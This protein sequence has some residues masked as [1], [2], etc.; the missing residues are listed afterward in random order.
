M[1]MRRVALPGI[2]RRQEKGK[3]SDLA[4][5]HGQGWFS[6]EEDPP[7][8]DIFQ[9]PFTVLRIAYFRLLHDEPDGHFKVNARMTPFFHGYSSH[10][11]SGD[12]GLLPSQFKHPGSLTPTLPTPR[13]AIRL[14]RY[15]GISA[16]PE[17]NLKN[18]PRDQGA[19]PP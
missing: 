11:Q 6:P 5:F 10:P 15:K 16:D 3:I 14:L 8:A 12:F 1:E 9:Y 17:N 18:R 19:Q 2:F 7:M 4:R 13:E